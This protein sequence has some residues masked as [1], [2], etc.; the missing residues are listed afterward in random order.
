MG[1]ASFNRMR[2]EQE[3]KKLKESKKSDLKKIKKSKKGTK[4]TENES[5]VEKDTN[6]EEESV[7]GDLVKE[8]KDDE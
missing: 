5:K 8:V 3:A 6:A 7:K 2:K 4:N 1:L